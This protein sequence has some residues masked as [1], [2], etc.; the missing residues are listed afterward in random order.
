[1]EGKPHGQGK[2]IW[3]DGGEWIGEYRDN[4]RWNGKG[5]IR[6]VDGYIYE[7]E[8]MEGKHH[9]QGKL[10]MNDGTV[11]EGEFRNGKY[12]NKASKF[13]SKLGIKF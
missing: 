9:G 3:K 11:Q 8:L 5:V 2:I 1:M 12:Q 10:I 7:G 6:Y 4:N 13:M